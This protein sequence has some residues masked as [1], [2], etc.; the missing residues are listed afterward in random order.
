MEN[1]FFAPNAIKICQF[2]PPRQKQ[3]QFRIAHSVVKQQPTLETLV[4][5]IREQ[6][7]MMFSQTRPQ[8]LKGISVFAPSFG[9]QQ[10]TI[11]IDDQ[12]GGKTNNNNKV[13]RSLQLFYGTGGTTR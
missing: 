1:R 11:D 9:Q 8:S 12:K 7:E 4:H 3:P 6:Q 13:L 2:L 10:N 5:K